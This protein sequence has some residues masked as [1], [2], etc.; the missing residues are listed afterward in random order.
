MAVGVIVGVRVGVFVGVAVAVFVLV[1][2]RV[3][4]FV[5]VGVAVLVGVGVSVS[6]GR[7]VQPASYWN[8]C[9]KPSSVTYEP[10]IRAFGANWSVIDSPAPSWNGVSGP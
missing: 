8:V 7:G 10:S 5:F 1:G 6:G 9:V 4:V 3:G 2:V